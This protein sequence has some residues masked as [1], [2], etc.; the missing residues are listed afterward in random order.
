MLTF[1]IMSLRK[2]IYFIPFLFIFCNLTV[3]S[4]DNLLYFMGNV[5]QS[6]YLNP[7]RLTDKSKV[8]INLPLLSGTNISLSNSFAFHDLGEIKDTSLSIDLGKF[9]SKIPFKNYF[10][11]TFSLPLFGFQYRSKDKLFSFHISE[12]QSLRF[13][14]DSDLIKLIDKGNYAFIESPFSTNLDF[15]FLHFRE[16]ALGYSQNITDKLTVGLNIKLLTGFSAFDVKRL[17]IGIETGSNLEYVKLSANGNYNVSFPVTLNSESNSNT[18]FNPLSYLTNSSNLGF[19]VDIGARYQILPKLE[20][21]A[22]L[23]DLGYIHWKTNIQNITQSGS[24]NW[25]GYD[26]SNLINEPTINENSYTAPF[27]A[28]LDSVSEMIKFKFDSTPFKTA[29]PTKLYMAAN[30]KVSP[31]FWA[32]V[33]DRILFYDKQVSNSLTL[34]GNL[35]LGRIFSLSAGYSIIDKSYNNLALGTALKLGPVEFYCLTGNIL[36]LNLLNAQNLSLQFGMNF[37]FGKNKLYKTDLKK[38]TQ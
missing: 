37:M 4:Q 10:S 32:G 11:E 16:Y 25:K 13:C 20:I 2:K 24:F 35:Q 19:A 31:I 3:K 5:P 6:N 17:N 9:Y 29:I 27:D 7:A 22:S 34:S 1:K 26:L 36:A 18:N 8:I 23:V 12:N 33:V 14:F 28:L 15:N 38:N 30:Y 21:S